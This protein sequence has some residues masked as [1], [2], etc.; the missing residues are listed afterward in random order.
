MQNPRMLANVEKVIMKSKGS[1]ERLKS[2]EERMAARRA[3]R[4]AHSRLIGTRKASGFQVIMRPRTIPNNS[5]NIL[6]SSFRSA[7]VC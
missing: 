4:A 2:V 1:Q 6:D 3:P 5:T 7:V